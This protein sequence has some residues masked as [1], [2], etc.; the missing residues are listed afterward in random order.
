MDGSGFQWWGVFIW[1]GGLG[2]GARGGGCGNGLLGGVWW[3][4][5]T[6]GRE[7]GVGRL[8]GFV[9]LLG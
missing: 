7:E 2:G 9:G 4:N 6:G 5:Y 8:F 1:E 3:A